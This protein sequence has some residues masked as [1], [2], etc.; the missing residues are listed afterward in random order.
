MRENRRI[1]GF[2]MLIA[3]Q[4]TTEFGPFDRSAATRVQARD[5]DDCP[6]CG[7][8]IELGECITLGTRRELFGVV[9]RWVHEIC[10]I[11][12][13]VLQV[14]DVKTSGRAISSVGRLRRPT[15][16]PECGERIRQGELSYREFLPVRQPDGSRSQYLCE[17]CAKGARR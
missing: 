14:M 9:E 1:L 4:D 15:R 2:R 8:P 11:H 3:F 17:D 5:V 16:C 12:E 6:A 13:G 10:P 7:M